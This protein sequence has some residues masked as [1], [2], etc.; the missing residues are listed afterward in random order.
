MKLRVRH[1]S[2]RFRLGQ[3][4]VERL[5]SLGCCGETILFPGGARLEYLLL[6]SESSRVQV[7]FADSVVSIAVPEGELADWHASNRVGIS[8]TVEVDSAQ[9]LE[10][11]IEKDFQCLDPR[12]LEDQSDGFENPLTAHLSCAV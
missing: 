2:I 5:R 1:N 9:E 10:V 12:V 11:L 8:A 6:A 7:T 4:D 3:S